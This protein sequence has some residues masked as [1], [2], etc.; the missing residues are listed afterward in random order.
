MQSR[1]LVQAAG[2]GQQSRYPQPA[3]SPAAA[4]RALGAA[5]APTS[6]NRCSG[7]CPGT[8]KGMLSLLNPL[9]PLSTNPKSHPTWL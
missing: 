5:L 8:A 2:T 3:T 4:A 1:S 9:D 7:G 6:S